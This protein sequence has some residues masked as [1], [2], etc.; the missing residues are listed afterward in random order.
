MVAANRAKARASML[1]VLTQKMLSGG[2]QLG[3]ASLRAVEKHD[4]RI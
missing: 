2:D 1:S 3:Q 4:G